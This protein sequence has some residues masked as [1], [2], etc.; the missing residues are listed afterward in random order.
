M[1]H[2]PKELPDANVEVVDLNDVNDN[3]RR[4]ATWCGLTLGGLPGGAAGAR[5]CSM[6]P[7]PMLSK[8]QMHLPTAA[9][10]QTPFCPAPQPQAET[11][12]TNSI[13]T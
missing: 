5:G 9:A 1:A 11:H 10:S 12:T 2:N 4:T 6:C 3:K 13:H 8:Y 7:R